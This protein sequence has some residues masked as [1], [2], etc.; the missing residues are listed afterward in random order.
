MSF[1]LE[2]VSPVKMVFE[3]EVNSI[4]IPGTLGSFQVLQNHAPLISTF[5]VGRIKVEKDS[6]SMEYSTSGGVF[7]VKNNKAIVLADSIETIEEIDI[8]RAKLSK[9]RAEE[10][11]KIADSTVDEKE[12]AKLALQRAENR[13]KVIENK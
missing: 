11:L 9:V 8:E 13:I 1:N 7:E 4:T 6:E 2:I 12:D 3:G 5:I 10:I